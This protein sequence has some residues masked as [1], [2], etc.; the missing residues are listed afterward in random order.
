MSGDASKSM[1]WLQDRHTGE[2]VEA[3]LL[4][5]I[6]EARLEDVEKYWMPKILTGLQRL[7]A[8]GKPRKDW[9]QSW[10]WNWREKVDHVR[11]ILAYRGFAIECEG[12]TQGLMQVKTTDVCRL[13]SQRGKPLVYVDY[14]ETAPWNQ[15]ELV[16]RP[17]FAGIGS[18]MLAAAI[19][20]SREEGFSGRIGLHSLPQ[21][22]KFYEEA[23]GMTNLGVDLSKQGLPYF[24]MT[25]EQS[26]AFFSK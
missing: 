16:E 13:P 8:A 17:R 2:M 4:D 11:G 23:C 20:L 19:T 10:H 25:P 5:G 6:P 18:V 15:R 14:L 21:S 26:A 7:A 12:K 22:E 3:L 24:E 1:I 9:P